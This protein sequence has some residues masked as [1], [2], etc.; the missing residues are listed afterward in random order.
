L[1]R[2]VLEQFQANV[3]EDDS[4]DFD[5]IPAKGSDGDI[6]PAESAPESPAGAVG[7]DGDAEAPSSPDTPPT[8]PVPVPTAEDDEDL[9][10]VIGD[11][12]YTEDEITAGLQV[13]SWVEGLNE[14]EIQTVDAALSGDYVLVPMADVPAITAFYESRQNPS[15]PQPSAAP[16]YDEYGYEQDSP[17]PARDPAYQ[18]LAAEVEQLRAAQEAEATQRN[19]EYTREAVQRGSDAFWAE[20]PDLSAKDRDRLSS[21]VMQAGVYQQALGSGQTPDQAAFTAL[22]AAKQADPGLMQRTVD[23]QVAERLAQER[24]ALAEQSRV[25]AGSTALSGSGAATN[26]TPMP[27]SLDEQRVEMIRRAMES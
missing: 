20:N 24:A 1:E 17:P 8:A 9:V 10:Y 23:A 21:A 22:N 6:I 2:Q 4:F 27:M 19:Y 7:E 15:T 12:E 14:T 5:K 3:S 13:K 18:A 16:G 25:N 26:G 11:N